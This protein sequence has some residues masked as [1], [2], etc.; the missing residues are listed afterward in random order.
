MSHNGLSVDASKIAY[1]TVDNELCATDETTACAVLCKLSSQNSAEVSFTPDQINVLHVQ[2]HAFKMLSQ[3]SPLPDS[4]HQAVQLSN[5]IIPDL[6][7]LLQ[8]PDQPSRLV[9]SIVKVS[10]SPNV[11]PKSEEKVGVL[12]INPADMPM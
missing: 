10:K 11:I 6:K 1:S 9:D 8:P 4:L 7:K 5:T 12:P 3:G 2:I